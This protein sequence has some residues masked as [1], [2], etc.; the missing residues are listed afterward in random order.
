MKR[1]PLQSLPLWLSHRFCHHPSFLALTNLCYG[2]TP[3]Q[4]SSTSLHSFSVNPHT[5]SF[6]LLGNS[7]ISAREKHLCLSQK[8]KCR[9]CHHCAWLGLYDQLVVSGWH[10]ASAEVGK[11]RQVPELVESARWYSRTRAKAV[12]SHGTDVWREA[13]VAGTASSGYGIMDLQASPLIH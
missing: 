6:W 1:S 10:A 3:P 13:E 7:V 4:N 12:K 8:S 2:Q 9:S 5:S 11:K